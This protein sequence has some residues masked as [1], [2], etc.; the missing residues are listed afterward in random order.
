MSEPETRTGYVVAV[1]FDPCRSQ[2]F[3]VVY[4]AESPTAPRSEF[5]QIDGGTFVADGRTVNRNEL[6]RWLTWD[7]DETRQIRAALTGNFGPYPTC[8]KAEFWQV[9]PPA[10]SPTAAASGS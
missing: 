8:E 4:L 5:H 10:P 1:N 6:I 3:T 9:R 2:W 7:G